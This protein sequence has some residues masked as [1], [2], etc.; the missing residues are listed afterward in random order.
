MIRRSRPNERRRHTRGRASRPRRSGAAPS[1][2]PATARSGQGTT[3]SRAA[4]RARRARPRMGS[5]VAARPGSCRRAGRSRNCGSS[6]R[7]DRRRKPPTRVTRGSAAI[8]AQVVS[9][10]A[11]SP[12]RSRSRMCSWCRRSSALRCMVLNFRTVN[13]RRATAEPDLA[14][15]DRPRR[16][17]LDRH[18]HHAEHRRDDRQADAGAED[19]EGTLGDA[20][21]GRRPRDR[22]LQLA[23]RQARRVGCGH[24]SVTVLRMVGAD[25]FEPS[26]SCSQSRCATRLRYAPRDAHESTARLETADRPR[27]PGSASAGPPTHM[28]RPAGGLPPT[29][30]RPPCGSAASDSMAAARAAGSPPRTYRIA[31]GSKW[32]RT[33][34]RS[35]G[36]DRDAHGHRFEQLGGQ[37]I[38][39]VRLGTG[40]DDGDVRT[41]EDRRE[42]VDGHTAVERHP[43]AATVARDPG[44]DLDRETAHHRRRRG[45]LRP[46]SRRATA[47]TATSS[48]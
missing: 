15:E 37:R 41:G 16:V 14:E 4:A 27:P 24:R 18:G 9:S 13:G 17:Q 20:I 40:R 5:G 39:E 28:A 48:P 21:A 29:A 31:D 42:L 3:D 46:G 12:V 23:R 30:P 43:I 19:V 1:R 38:R 47:S 22:D 44:L 10:V 7:C 11:A 45:G 33:V 26:T 34:C 36:D 35:G 32:R 6:S 25:G 2:R 8:G